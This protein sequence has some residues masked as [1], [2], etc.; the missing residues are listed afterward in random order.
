MTALNRATVTSIAPHGIWGNQALAQFP[1]ATRRPH[2]C[3]VAPDIWPA[4][5]ADYESEVIGGAEIQQCRIARLLAEAGYRVSIICLDYGQPR[6]VIRDGITVL[7]TYRP[8][9]GIPVV[10]FLHPRLTGMWQ[11]MRAIDADIYYQRSASMLTAIVAA[12]CRRHGKRSIYAGASSTDFVPGQQLIE[13]R[14]DR[15]LFEKGIA[16]TDVVIA[17][18]E[19]QKRD[20]L[21]YYGRTAIVIPNVYELPKH[22]SNRPGDYVLWVARMAD[23]KRPEL[24]LEAARQLPHRRFIMIGGSNGSRPD[25][26]KYYETVRAAAV[27]LPNVAFLG[28]LPAA[29]VE[30]YFDDARV[31]VSTSAAEGTPNVFLQ[32]WARG[33]P[34]VAYCDVD[35]RLRGRP[36]YRVVDNTAALSAE[37]ERMFADDIY[38]AHASANSIEYFTLNHG[39]LEIR[40]R[41]RQLLGSLV[42]ENET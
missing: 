31:F 22:F 29:K 10:R 35:A 20:C 12:F 38:R 3:F 41:Y 28:F 4:F 6:K 42:P 36:L 5:S 7:S 30:Q 37:I 17:Q 39:T 25:V 14:R 23:K 19:T 2:I 9:A 27:G 32:A 40:R 26:K 34:T 8:N 15:W 11:A 24:L 16:Q 13:Y 21:K 18:T 33:I 1:G